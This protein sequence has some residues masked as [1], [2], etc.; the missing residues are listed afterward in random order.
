M[1]RNNFKQSSRPNPVT[2]TTKGTVLA[3][4]AHINQRQL[5]SVNYRA[6][7]FYVIMIEL[8]D[9]QQSG[10]LQ[11]VWTVAARVN[12]CQLYSDNYQ[13]IYFYL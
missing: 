5:Y 1:Q 4:W 2:V 6:I 7:Y 10:R 12:K 3:H 8:T 9:K 11:T 13:A